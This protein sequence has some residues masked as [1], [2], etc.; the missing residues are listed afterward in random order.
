MKKIHSDMEDAGLPAPEY[1]EGSNTVRL[2]LRNN[3]DERMPHRNTAS[4]NF[5][6]EGS[7]NKI[8]R[9]TRKG[10]F[11]CATGTGQKNLLS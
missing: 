7:N 6:G 5:S 9:I 8:N 10:Y 1:I 3:I 2:I 4:D 11:V